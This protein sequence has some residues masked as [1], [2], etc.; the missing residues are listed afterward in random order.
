[1]DRVRRLIRLWHWL[2][3]FRAVAET[4]HLPSASQELGIT[5]P[6]LSRS[7][8]L[9]EEDLGQ[10]LFLRAARRLQLNEAG[11][12]FLSALRTAM[13]AL[14]EGLDQIAQR[15]YTGS[16]SIASY[17]HLTSVL[18]HPLLAELCRGYPAIVPNVVRCDPDEV[19]SKLCNGSIDIALLETP[20]HHPEL[21]VE[22]LAEMTYGLYCG[23]EHP[24]ARANAVPVAELIQHAFVVLSG[25]QDDHWPLDIERRVS[26]RVPT[27]HDALHFC[28]GGLFVAVL[29]D[30]L[31][32][33]MSGNGELYQ[34]PCELSLVVPVFAMYRRPISE[35]AKLNT[36]LDALRARIAGN[37]PGLGSPRRTRSVDDT[38]HHLP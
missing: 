29:P 31:V 15:E 28:R 24:L 9:L 35:H 5:A 7:I 21:V 16:L 34:V 1:M 17:G 19:C 3:A 32:A 12:L 18:L 27:I 20:Q 13:R 22:Q 8:R 33:E 4:M 26:L 10:P 38:D 2:P 14:D 6:A 36:F 25:G 37:V 23:R 30:A 11:E